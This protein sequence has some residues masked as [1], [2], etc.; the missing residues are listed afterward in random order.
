MF[1]NLQ[2]FTQTPGELEYH[3]LAIGV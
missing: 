3:P 1:V 2:P